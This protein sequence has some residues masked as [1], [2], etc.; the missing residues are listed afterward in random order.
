[1]SPFFSEV[2]AIDA[3]D[4]DNAYLVAVSVGTA[5]VYYI[6]EGPKNKGFA[7]TVLPPTR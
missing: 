4:K 3:P 7:V 2:V 1:M 6:P 5:R